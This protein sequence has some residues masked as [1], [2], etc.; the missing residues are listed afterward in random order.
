VNSPDPVNWLDEATLDEGP[1]QKNP[2]RRVPDSAAPRLQRARRAKFLVIWRPNCYATIKSRA[3]QS[4]G[5]K[6]VFLAPVSVRRFCNGPLICQHF[7]RPVA[8]A[9]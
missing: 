5:I 4:A 9:W 6:Y 7:H 2:D 3:K 8:P 1:K